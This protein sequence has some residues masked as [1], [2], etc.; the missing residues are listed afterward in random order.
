[1]LFLWYLDY[2]YL[3]SS[4]FFLHSFIENYGTHIITS[5]TI[6]GQD[7]VYVKQQN[8]SLLSKIDIEKYVKDIGDQRFKDSDSLLSSGPVSSKVSIL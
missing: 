2:L 3:S 8:S 6:G 4:C 5:V 1:M 7:V